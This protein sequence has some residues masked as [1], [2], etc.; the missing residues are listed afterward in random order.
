MKNQEIEILHSYIHC[1][2]S[3]VELP[4]DKTTDDVKDV[5]IKWDE[6]QLEFKDGSVIEFEA[7]F[8]CE[9]D[10]KRPYEIKWETFK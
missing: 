5:W 2:T 1:Q 8:D 7:E 3:I 9:P 4:K 6:G 10:F